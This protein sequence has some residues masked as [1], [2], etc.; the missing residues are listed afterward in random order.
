MKGNNKNFNIGKIIWHSFVIILSI[1]SI[2]EVVVGFIPFPD[3]KQEVIRF[4][5]LGLALIGAFYEVVNRLFED[6]YNKN[7]L[8]KYIEEGL[9]LSKDDIIDE[10]ALFQIE[11]NLDSCE[12]KKLSSIFESVV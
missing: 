6:F 2:I 8:E 5:F 4:L 3:D 1:A 7:N 11:N 10:M 12:Y 9:M